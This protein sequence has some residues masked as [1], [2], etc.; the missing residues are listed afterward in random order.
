M[1]V[2]VY[3]EI[4]LSS[5][6]ISD[7]MRRG[8]AGGQRSANDELSKYWWQSWIGD[9]SPASN[10]NKKIHINPA[11]IYQV[12]SNF[13]FYIFFFH[14]NTLGARFLTQMDLNRHARRFKVID[15][16]RRAG[17]CPRSFGCFLCW[18][19]LKHSH[20]ARFF[21]SSAQSLLSSI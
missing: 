7:W 16:D 6:I 18:C 15:F 4:L 9:F 19:N 20:I 2:T 12:M 8:M 14:L 17:W 1:T 3:L 10:N 13:S 5:V 11:S 21:L